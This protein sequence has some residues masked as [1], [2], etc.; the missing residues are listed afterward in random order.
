MLLFVVA[1]AQAQNW[2]FG[3]GDFTTAEASAV[4]S[5]VTLEVTDTYTYVLLDTL[6]FPATI[7]LD[8]P[9]K[10][11]NGAILLIEVRSDGTGRDVTCGDQLVCATVSGQANKGKIISFF[12]DPTRDKF[13]HF[14]TQQYD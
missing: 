14:A 13:V 5:T 7:H 6:A 10:L 11:K 3:K 8:T 12:Y 9:K 1:G 2:P 4:D